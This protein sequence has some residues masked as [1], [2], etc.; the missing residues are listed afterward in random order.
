MPECLEC[1]VLQKV[2]YINTLTFYLYNSVQ[3]PRSS[4]PPPFSRATSPSLIVCLDLAY[5]KL[6]KLTAANSVVY[7][8]LAILD[9]YLALASIVTCD[10]H[11]DGTVYSLLHVGVDRLALQTKA[12]VPLFMTEIYDV[13]RKTNC[14]KTILS[15]VCRP[16]KISS[17]KGKKLLS[18]RSSAIVQNFMPISSTVAEISVRGQKEKK[19]YSRSNIQQTATQVVAG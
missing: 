2:R 19:K 15:V 6:L 7:A 13:M 11:L 3:H 16:L 5:S 9:K 4:P 10:Q 12:A 1:E 18:G 17:A 8:I 14:P